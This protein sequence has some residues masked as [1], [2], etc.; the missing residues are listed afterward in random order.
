MHRLSFSSK[1]I[2]GLNGKIGNW[3]VIT[4]IGI[5]Q[6]V[7]EETATGVHFRAF[8]A[9]TAEQ[10]KNEIWNAA[11]VVFGEEKKPA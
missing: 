3:A 8:E 1:T 6:L 7:E 4:G 10:L 11:A 9:E 2:E 5:G